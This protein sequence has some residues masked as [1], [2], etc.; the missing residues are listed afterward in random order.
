MNDKETQDDAFGTLYNSGGGNTPGV[1][2]KQ[3][4]HYLLMQKAGK[5]ETPNNLAEKA[6][7]ATDFVKLLNMKNILGE[8]TEGFPIQTK[9][10]KI[11]KIIQ[12]F[13]SEFT[14]LTPQ[15]E[16]ELIQSL[17]ILQ[18]SV[19]V[20]NNQ[21]KT[22][23]LVRVLM[24]A[25][26]STLMEQSAIVDQATK[27]SIKPIRTRFAVVTEGVKDLFRSIRK[28]VLETGETIQTEGI[29]FIKDIPGIS[30]VYGVYQDIRA[31]FQ[32]KKMQ[33]DMKYRQKQISALNLGTNSSIYET[34]INSD[35]VKGN[36]MGLINK[37]IDY[38]DFLETELDGKTFDD[39]VKI[40][41]TK[42]PEDLKKDPQMTKIFNEI[43]RDD[44]LGLYLSSSKGG[45]L[46]DQVSDD[47][48]RMG[49][50]YQFL[51]KD[52]G[53]TPGK[54]M[55][56]LMANNSWFTDTNSGTSST[57]LQ[58]LRK[59]KSAGA[60]E[61]LSAIEQAA[62][63]QSV[64]EEELI[65]RLKSQA[66]SLRSFM[67]T[68]LRGTMGVGNSP[69]SFEDIGKFSQ[70][71]GGF[72]SSEKEKQAW[73]GIEK[74]QA[75]YRRY[76]DVFE[77]LGNNPNKTITPQDLGFAPGT[78]VNNPE[79]VK[80]LKDIKDYNSGFVIDD[81]QI[82]PNLD[83][84]EF[85]AEWITRNFLGS[86]KVKGYENLGNSI[87][88]MGLDY[89]NKGVLASVLSSESFAPKMDMIKGKFL[90][91][92]KEQSKRIEKWKQYKERNPDIKGDE[93][94]EINDRIRYLS[95]GLNDEIMLMQ[96]K[97]PGEFAAMIEMIAKVG[98][99]NPM[100]LLNPDIPNRD[101][102]QLN[103]IKSQKIAKL[104]NAQTSLPELKKAVAKKQT[105]MLETQMRSKKS[106]FKFS[107]TERQS[108]EK[109]ANQKEFNLIDMIIDNPY[110]YAKLS[111]QE[112]Q[113][114][115][116]VLPAR[117]GESSIYTQ[118]IQLNS[119]KDRKKLIEQQLQQK[120]EAI[121]PEY[122]GALSG[123]VDKKKM[124]EN[125][126]YA[127]SGDL[128][129]M[130][131]VG[132]K[133]KL[134]R[135]LGLTL[136][137][138][139]K[140]LSFASLMKEYNKPTQK[141]IR[142]AKGVLAFIGDKS[143]V[144]PFIDAINTRIAILKYN[145]ITMKAEAKKAKELKQRKAAEKKNRF[146]NL[147]AALKGDGAKVR[148]I[149]E[150]YEQLSAKDFKAPMGGKSTVETL[151][152][153]METGKAERELNEQEQQ[154]LNAVIKGIFGKDASLQSIAKMGLDKTT[155]ADKDN[156]NRKAKDA[157]L[158]Q[159]LTVAG[160]NSN[161][162]PTEILDILLSGN[163]EWNQSTNKEGLKDQYSEQLKIFGKIIQG[164][165]NTGKLIITDLS[166]E[167]TN[168]LKE[169]TGVNL[170]FIS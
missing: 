85:R 53:F 77:A 38:S 121:D 4:A 68:A 153:F 127:I 18:D 122:Y 109:K 50:M 84:K 99:V 71:T 92:T 87:K 75:D 78:P 3:L 56:D 43:Q 32:G 8:S 73:T 132:D 120:T 20:G 47:K 167:E 115:D 158:T 130:N 163:A 23:E 6:R 119:K 143:G 134:A 96:Q 76:K 147:E 11:D 83:R 140:E 55:T 169:L 116:E 26:M 16:K 146:A 66:K 41:G 154:K 2:D 129:S 49:Y 141:L 98:G 15:I 125:Q 104:F 62:K 113:I 145:N 46:I 54:D 17:T 117:P 166:T 70:M 79:F 39:I 139:E 106:G 128:E 29:P 108:F 13:T 165:I 170:A 111:K 148:S 9:N 160:G 110:A 157:W 103:K 144:T 100:K 34:L 63:S 64:T 94:N 136:E 86:G 137:Q 152:H 156:K 24:K 59:E 89:S 5:I 30:S 123:N 90:L 61:L 93:L 27:D 25:Q 7:S 14:Q 118:L 10:F 33:K 65:R 142:S 81:N 114:I 28:G 40:T 80:L 58:N 101:L 164:Y 44:S 36:Q 37:I 19:A 149:D 107:D 105:D 155:L 88:T 126:L 51:M 45:Q 95:M 162:L 97:Q 48:Y 60:Q 124:T 168:A 72:L 57:F 91:D 82:P 138:L 161:R 1:E 22:A 102:Q 21:G 131:T 135:I 112:Q 67:A 133:E 52:Q 74:F 42:S 31:D 151:K 35:M 12:A 69:V 159:F 150:L